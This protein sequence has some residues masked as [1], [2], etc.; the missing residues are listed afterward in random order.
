MPGHTSQITQNHLNSPDFAKTWNLVGTKVAKLEILFPR[1]DV[2][3]IDFSRHLLF[4]RHSKTVEG[5]AP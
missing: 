3:N 1:S 2:F 4:V 5:E